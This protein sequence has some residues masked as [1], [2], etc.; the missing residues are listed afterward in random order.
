LVKARCRIDGG[1][2]E[3]QLKDRDLIRTINGPHRV[4]V[5]PDVL[6]SLRYRDVGNDHPGRYQPQP[7]ESAGTHG[8]PDEDERP[9]LADRSMPLDI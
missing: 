5:H 2:V 1:A 9:G 6:V 3:Q 4:D 8:S 7:G